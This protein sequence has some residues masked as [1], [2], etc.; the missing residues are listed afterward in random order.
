MQ[1]HRVPYLKMCLVIASVL[2]F[3]WVIIAE[4]KNRDCSKNLS[5]VEVDSLN[6]NKKKRR[7]EKIK[8]NR[9]SRQR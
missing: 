4:R 9:A 8:I 2:M 3:L 7:Q 1:T 6:H 5:D